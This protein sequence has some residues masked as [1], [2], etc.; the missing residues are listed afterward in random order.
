MFGENEALARDVALMSSVVDDVI[1]YS[2]TLLPSNRKRRG[3]PF[4][5]RAPET[6]EPTFSDHTTA[7]NSAYSTQEDVGVELKEDDEVSSGDRRQ[8]LQHGETALWSSRGDGEDDV[9]DA[10]KELDAAEVSLKLGTS[11]RTDKHRESIILQAASEAGLSEEPAPDAVRSAAGDLSPVAPSD[12]ASQRKRDDPHDC[13]LPQAASPTSGL[14][15]SSAAAVSPSADAVA[16]AAAAAN[17]GNPV[18]HG[19]NSDDSRTTRTASVATISSAEHS[20]SRR[21]SARSIEDKGDLCKVLFF[22]VLG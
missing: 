3:N 8:S 5:T 15:Q 19:N 18:P 1:E 2:P 16:A 12:T 10:L 14:Q 20:P 17:G 13:T 9:P 4:K 22:F 7:P 11:T 21:A 6:A